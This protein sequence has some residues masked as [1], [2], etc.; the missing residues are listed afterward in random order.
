[1][2]SA[3]RVERCDRRRRCLAAGR[4]AMTRVA[5]EF[6]WATAQYESG[7]WDSAPLVGVNLTDSVAR[8]TAIRVAATP[9]IVSLSSADVMRYP[10]LFLTG[11]LPVRFN[12]A[13]R[14]NMRSYVD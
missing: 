6:Q 7:D 12:E 8:Y 11:H 2:R 4:L 5:S 13:E 9:A 10:F 14:A 1:S 3:A